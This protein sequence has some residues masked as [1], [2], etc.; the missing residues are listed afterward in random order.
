VPYVGTNVGRLGVQKG[1]NVPDLVH[2]PV[3]ADTPCLGAVALA[4]PD[5]EPVNAHP[6]PAGEHL[7]GDQPV[8][9]P[10]NI[11]RYAG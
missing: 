2:D 11:I 10:D 8:L 3:A 9:I 4:K 6:Q 5:V 7:A 1:Q